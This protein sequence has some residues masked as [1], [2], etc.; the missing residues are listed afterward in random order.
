V[1]RRSAEAVT[2][3]FI[4][5]AKAESMAENPDEQ[6]N[7]LRGWWGNFANYLLDKVKDVLD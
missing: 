1:A 6:Y 3:L 5:Y 4:A 7:D 2:L